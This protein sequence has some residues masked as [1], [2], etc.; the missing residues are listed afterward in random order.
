MSRF[1]FWSNDTGTWAPRDPQ[2]LR[3]SKETMRKTAW[4]LANELGC[5]VR[6]F[7][8]RPGGLGLLAYETKGNL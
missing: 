5:Q 6:A 1:T 3:M 4:S 2:F 8:E 7:R